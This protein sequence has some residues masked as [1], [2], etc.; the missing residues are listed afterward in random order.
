MERYLI[1]GASRG[2]GRVLAVRLARPE[3]TIVVQGRNR[4]GLNETRR[5]VEE[6]GGKVEAIIGELDTPQGVEA[7]VAAMAGERLDALVNNAAVSNVAGINELTVEQWQEAVAVNITAPFLLVKGLLPRMEKGST[8]VNV[9]SVANKVT[10][11]N[12]SAY[13]MSKAALEGF[14]R[15]LREE[16]RGWGIRVID[17]YPA[18]TATEL[19]DD[20]PGEWNRAGMLQPE[21]AAEAI[22]YAIE[23]PSE[24]LVESIS[25]GSVGGNL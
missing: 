13:T 9:L 17:V 14:S 12:W 6:A 24:V 15:V 11:P 18:A 3:R 21:E 1:T 2:I 7:V 25:V 4:E 20:V 23:R 16:V 5:L 10:F 22:A 8:I 19:W